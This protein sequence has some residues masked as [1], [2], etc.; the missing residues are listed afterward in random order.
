M[1][2]AG[3]KIRKLR[4]DKSRLISTNYELARRFEAYRNL[5][6]NLVD[7]SQGHLTALQ[8]I[9]SIVN[10]G[11]VDDDAAGKIRDI[12]NGRLFSSFNEEEPNDDPQSTISDF[13]DYIWK[14]FKK[15]EGRRCFDDG[16]LGFFTGRY[17]KIKKI[18]ES[19]EFKKLE[20]LVEKKEESNESV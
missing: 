18:V 3:E 19:D 13:C 1:D 8:D 12:C 17:V 6:Y 11:P 20:G 9:V 10:S 5:F 2:E 7:S 4:E 15:D 14:E 16:E